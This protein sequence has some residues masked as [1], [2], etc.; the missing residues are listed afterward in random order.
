MERANSKGLTNQIVILD[1]EAESTHGFL[2][3]GCRNLMYLI[4]EAKAQLTKGF[5]T[6]K[7]IAIVA[8]GI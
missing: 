1:E 8:V 3:L 4:V 5:L 6:T 7:L 2:G